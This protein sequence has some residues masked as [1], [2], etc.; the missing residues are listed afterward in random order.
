MELKLPKALIDDVSEKELKLYLA[1][2]LFKER[3]ISIGQ[4][5]RLSGLTL[6]D[7]MYEIGKHKEAFTNIS[8]DELEE[9]LR[10]IK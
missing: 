2:M 9:E 4:A 7:F 10:R 8:E 5:A 6:L 3:K 1:I